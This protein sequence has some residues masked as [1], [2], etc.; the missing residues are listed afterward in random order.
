MPM[1]LAIW[2][3]AR[4]DLTLGAIA[5]TSGLTIRIS[6]MSGW[7]MWTAINVFESM[8]TVQEGL[9]TIARPNVLTDAPGAKALVDFLWAILSGIAGILVNLFFF[10]AFHSISVQVPFW[11]FAGLGTGIALKFGGQ[12]QEVYRLWHYQH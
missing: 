8:G 10:D 9:E 12:R 7:I 4:G 2:L 5:L 3:W 1:A 11:I 6:T